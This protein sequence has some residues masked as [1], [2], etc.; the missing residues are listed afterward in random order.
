MSPFLDRRHGTELCIIEQ[1][2]RLATQYGWDIQ[3]Y[4]QRVD[5]IPG[6]TFP[7]SSDSSPGAGKIV[8]HKVSQIPGPHL[9]KFIWWF[10]ANHMRRMRDRS[11]QNRNPDVTY[12]PGINCLDAGAVIVHMVFHEFYARIRSELRLRS[13][14]LRTWPIILHRKL[15]YRLI[16]F[17]ERR[18]YSNPK[19]RLAAVSQ[20]VASQLSMYFARTDVTIIPSAVDTSR[21]SCSSRLARRSTSRTLFN[22]SDADFVLLLIGNDWKVKGLDQLLRAIELNPDLP[23][24]LLV[25]G[26]DEP[27]LYVDRLRQSRIETRIAFH[28]PSPD[29]MQFYAAA[30]AYVGPSLQDSFG[31]PVLEAMACGLP[32]ISSARSGVSAFIAHGQNG[33][34][35]RDPERPEELA[36]SLKQLFENKSLQQKLGAAAVETAA[37]HTWDR[38]AE[39]THVFLISA[40]TRRSL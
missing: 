25:V 10:L 2:E 21:F 40:A 11:S 28:Q 19:V 20:L 7:S 14:P 8:W 13:L 27:S 37:R 18:V 33:L 1:I 31:L 32:V 23:F 35:L 4:S 29:V 6:I 39:L 3:V 26:R 22:F 15:Y 24:R 38:N 34:L 9:L 12:S 17:L 30:D 36:A 5:D 16:M